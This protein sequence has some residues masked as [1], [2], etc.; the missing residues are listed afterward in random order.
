MANPNIVGITTVNGVTTYLTPANN[1]TN[2]LLSNA[3]ASGKVYKVNSLIVSNVDTANA[4]PV[5]VTVNSAAAG[6]GT[7]YP[8]AST[9]SVPA[10][11]SLIVIDKTTMFYLTENQSIVVT[12]GTASKLTYVISYEDMS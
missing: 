11:A 3:A 6:G 1:T 10:N 5:T 7:A 9:I 4:I 12:S 2:V 8:I